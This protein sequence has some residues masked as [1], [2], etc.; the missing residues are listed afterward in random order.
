M[1][2]IGGYFGLEELPGRALYSDYP[3]FNCARSALLYAI[4]TQNV[5]KLYL[6]FFLCGCVSGMCERYHIPYA[7]Y[8]IGKDFL[9]EALSLQPGEALYLV[10]YYGMHGEQTVLQQATLY[11]TLILDNVQAYFSAPVPG[12]D[13]I[14]S[15]RKFFGVPDGAFLITDRESGAWRE[16]PRESSVDCMRHLNGRLENTASAYYSVFKQRDDAFEQ[17]ELCRPSLTAENIL[18]AIDYPAVKEK[19]EQNYAFLQQR[20]SPKN[21]LP[22]SGP[23]GPYAYPFLLPEQVDGPA[24]RRALAKEGIYV[25][26]LWPDIPTDS[27][28][29]EHDLAANLLPLPCDQR[30]DREDMMILSQKLEALL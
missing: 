3:A 27:N 6:P 21:R 22:V 13:T 26:T 24:V 14:Y 23:P 12:I 19:R 8:H 20:W 7:F 4:R 2:E 15:C 5:R 30:Y 16:L 29:F 18:R 10:N 1:R 28:S 11:P 9:P 17:A 25:P